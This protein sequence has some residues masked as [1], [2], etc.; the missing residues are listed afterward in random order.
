[1]K[2]NLQT[3]IILSVKRPERNRFVYFGF[4]KNAWEK[5]WCK[6]GRRFVV[7]SVTAW[8]EISFY[9]FREQ[10]CVRPIFWK[11]GKHIIIGVIFASKC[12]KL[13]CILM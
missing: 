2:N 8:S 3:I 4:A 1:M 9:H 12:V 10:R 7:L 11:G 5:E 13:S 6:D